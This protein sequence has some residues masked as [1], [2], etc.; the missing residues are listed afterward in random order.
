MRLIEKKQNQKSNLFSSLINF[1]ASAHKTYL[2]QGL[3]EV[4]KHIRRGEKGYNI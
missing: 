4:Q 2:R 3:K 1:V